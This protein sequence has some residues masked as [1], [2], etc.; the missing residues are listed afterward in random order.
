MGIKREVSARKEKTASTFFGGGI[1]QVLCFS[2]ILS[3]RICKKKIGEN[4]L[5]GFFE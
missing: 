4:S 5:S 1:S 3:R 2:K